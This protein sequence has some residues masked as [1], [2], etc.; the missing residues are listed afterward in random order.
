MINSTLKTPIESDPFRS[1]SQ[2]AG[3]TLLGIQHKS[4]ISMPG[5]LGSR[6]GRFKKISYELGAFAFRRD[7]I[8]K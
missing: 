3:N 5:D 4:C 8:L 6:S 1:A 7:V 2:Y